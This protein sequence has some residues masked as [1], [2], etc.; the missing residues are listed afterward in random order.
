MSEHFGTPHINLTHLLVCNRTFFA[1]RIPAAFS[2]ILFFILADPSAY[3][4]N[5]RPIA[6]F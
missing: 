3:P 1:G 6:I 2:P 4:Y 5:G